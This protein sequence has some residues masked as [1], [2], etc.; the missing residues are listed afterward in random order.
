VKLS[1]RLLGA[2]LAVLLVASLIAVVQPLFGSTSEQIKVEAW[3][4]WDVGLPP[5]LRA[6]L[7]EISIVPGTNSRP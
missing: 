2:V 4:V 5:D 7:Y 1:G 6:S 3:V